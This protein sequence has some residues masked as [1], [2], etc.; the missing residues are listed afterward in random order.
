[1]KK[2]SFL[3]IALIIFSCNSDDDNIIDQNTENEGFLNVPV[4]KSFLLNEKWF[5]E[6]ATND[7]P[8]D[9]NGDGNVSTDLKSQVPICDLDSFYIFEQN[10]EPNT[11]VLNDSND[12]CTNF[13]DRYGP[14]VFNFEII[15]NVGI[16]FLVDQFELLG[17][18]KGVTFF[19]NPTFLV[20]EDTTSKLI[21]ATVRTSINGNI[22]NIQYSLIARAN[23]RP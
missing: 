20:K 5:L 9:F 15:P 3:I 19:S 10:N 13:I 17:G 6:S 22:E 14:S 2:I 1:M 11:V 8:I 18:F 7:T 4:D 21:I 16:Q 12:T 23:E